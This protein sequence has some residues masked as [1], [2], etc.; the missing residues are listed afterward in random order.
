MSRTERV[1]FLGPSLQAASSNDITVLPPAQR[2]DIY[3]AFKRGARVIG[4]VDGLFRDVPAVLH[5][6]VLWVIAHAG[7]VLGAASMGALRAAELTEFGMMGIGSIFSDFRDGRLWR[8]DEVAIEHGPAELGF[9]ATSEALVNIRYT[10]RHAV[11]L[12]QLTEEQAQNLIAIA[13]AMFFPD[14]KYGEIF[15]EYR[16]KHGERAL[17]VIA[18]GWILSNK[19]DQKA[20]DAARLLES[21]ENVTNPMPSATRPFAFQDTTYFHSYRERLSNPFL[22]G[23]E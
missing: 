13:A 16:A 11:D 15:K 3:R 23:T 1:V 8:D 18:E 19:I 7:V 22:K 6:E 17:S 4:L 12:R 9:R 20:L 14:R 2:G 10:F 5:K 21:M